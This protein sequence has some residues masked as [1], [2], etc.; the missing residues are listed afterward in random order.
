MYTLTF[1]GIAGPEADIAHVRLYLGDADPIE[2]GI[3]SSEPFEV[4][5]RWPWSGPLEVSYSY[6]DVAGNE[7]ARHN[8]VIVIPDIEAPTA[9]VA[10]LALE[11]VTWS[12]LE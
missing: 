5:A 2:H 7:S 4:I 10:D 3:M 12:V 9:P 11:S 6:V 1:A 8:Q